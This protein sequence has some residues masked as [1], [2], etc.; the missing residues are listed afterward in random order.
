MSIGRALGPDAPE[1]MVMTRSV[2]PDDRKSCKELD[3]D[4]GGYGLAVLSPKDDPKLE[5]SKLVLA[6]ISESR[7]AARI[8]FSMDRDELKA[9]R[10]RPAP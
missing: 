9:I 10:A 6:S 1:F 4:W 3:R 7:T 8:E 2:W 5:K